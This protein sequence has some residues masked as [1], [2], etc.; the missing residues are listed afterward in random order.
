MASTW[1]RIGLGAVLP[2]TAALLGGT[3]FVHA[4][5]ANRPAVSTAILS[6]SPRTVRWA[7]VYKV[8]DLAERDPYYHVEVI[9]KE[10]HT[11]PWQF[12]RFAT[13]LVVTSEALD[14]SRLKQKAKTY[15]YKDIEFRIAYQAWREQSPAQR[16]AVVCRTAILECIKS[17]SE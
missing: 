9:E 11:P 14:R 1:L 15:F 16:E 10:R 8:P 2:A 3:V 4:E 7:T 12:K 13:H 17:D 5:A 6:L